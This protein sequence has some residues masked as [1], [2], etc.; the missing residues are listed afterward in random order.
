MIR[1]KLKKPQYL[2][3]EKERRQKPTSLE[4]FFKNSPE[5]MAE[6]GTELKYLSEMARKGTPVS[7]STGYRFV[8][9]NTMIE[10]GEGYKVRS[11]YDPNNPKHVKMLELPFVPVGRGGRPPTEEEIRA[12]ERKEFEDLCEE[13]GIEFD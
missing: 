9:G 1:I 7:R 8:H 12:R 2:I 3:S 5:L 6:A 10:V 11:P 4:L 13:L